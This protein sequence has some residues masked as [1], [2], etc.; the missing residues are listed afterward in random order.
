MYVMGLQ[1]S[2]IKNWFKC[3]NQNGKAELHER[4][5]KQYVLS[6]WAELLIHRCILYTFIG[7]EVPSIFFSPRKVKF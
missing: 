2:W 6:F 7:G 3:Q 5:T 1:V 4:L